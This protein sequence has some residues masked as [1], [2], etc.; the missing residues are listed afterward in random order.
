LLRNFLFFLI[1]GLIFVSGRTEAKNL[2]FSGDSGR[3]DLSGALSF[4]E[5]RKL[6][7][8]EEQK[9]VEGRFESFETLPFF[10]EGAKAVESPVVLL[11]IGMMYCP[12]CKAA[13]P[14]IEAISRLNPLVRTKYLVR[15][16]TPGAREFMK[17]RTGRANMPAIFVVRADGKVLDGAYVETPEKVTKMLAET[18]EENRDAIWDD[19]HNGVYDEDIQR[20]IL[21]LISKAAANQ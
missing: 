16:E 9:A 5:Y 18:P 21:D 8:G 7:T 14:Y 4:E 17:N 6:G 19:F 12:D 11:M 13:Y 2:V 20:D 15:N 1:L 3:V 10:E